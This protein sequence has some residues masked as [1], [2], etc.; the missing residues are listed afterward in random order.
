MKRFTATVAIALVLFGCAPVHH[1]N[2]CALEHDRD[3]LNRALGNRRVLVELT[4]RSPYARAVTLRAESV[5]VG[6]DSTQM[7][8]LREPSNTGAVFV[9]PTYGVRRDTTLGTH[10]VGRIHVTTRWPG[11]FT[12][13][14]RGLLVGAAS[15]ALFGAASYEEPDVLFGSPLESAGFG[16]VLFGVAGAGIGLLGGLLWGVTETYE[17]TASSP[18]EP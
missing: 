10:E 1:V 8:V 15:G 9:E 11:V 16:A 13:I 2:P 3:D 14:W 4:A 6:A 12:A 7:T 17:F 18:A 5:R